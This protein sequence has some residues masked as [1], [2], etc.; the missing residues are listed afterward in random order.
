M[1]NKLEEKIDLIIENHLTHIREDVINLKTDTDW[2]K[3]F[4]WLILSTSI[5][6]IIIN[7]LK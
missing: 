7:I 1:K 6:A 2:L 3:K 4:Q 5:G